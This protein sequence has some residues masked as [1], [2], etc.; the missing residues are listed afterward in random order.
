MHFPCPQ[1]NSQIDLRILGTRPLN[2]L[3]IYRWG[4]VV[5]LE[6]EN[7]KSEKVSTI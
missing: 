7:L 6:I 2:A 3:D 1:K 4:Q 5:E